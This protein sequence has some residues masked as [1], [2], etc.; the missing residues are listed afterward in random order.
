MPPLASIWQGATWVVEAGG[1]ALVDG[2]THYS[3]H[4]EL[5]T[6]PFMREE[7]VRAGGV[8]PRLWTAHAVVVGAVFC[9]AGPRQ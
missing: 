2:D 7:S 1:L 3:R 4:G 9:F 8:L 5:D 6:V